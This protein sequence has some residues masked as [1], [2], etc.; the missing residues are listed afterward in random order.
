METPDDRAELDDS[1]TP[2]T[3]MS[4]IVQPHAGSRLV[5]RNPPACFYIDT[6]HYPYFLDCLFHV[7][8]IQLSMSC[9]QG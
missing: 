3:A 6:L 8:C 5:G 1:G 2:S 4:T 9:I 7:R